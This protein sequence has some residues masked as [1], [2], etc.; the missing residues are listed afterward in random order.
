MAHPMHMSLQT[1][2]FED[3]EQLLA[4]FNER[5]AAT[6]AAN[7]ACTPQFTFPGTEQFIINPATFPTSFRMPSP[8]VSP[9]L[10]SP[11]SSFSVDSSS[12]SGFV[13]MANIVPPRND[14]VFGWNSVSIAQP[15]DESE[16]E[17]H[18]GRNSAEQT[19]QQS[20]RS[21]TTLKRP[22]SPSPTPSL[23]S[24][25]STSPAPMQQSDIPPA[26]TPT[27]KRARA[28]IS[29]K[30]FVPPD[31]SGLSKRE[32]RLVKNR[33]AAFLSRQRKREEFEELEK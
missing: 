1:P 3:N 20:L 24:S 30:D 26:P 10:S 13:S 8:P 29:S 7:P 28:Q 27:P 16:M 32:A 6:W 19:L 33:A 9:S 4:S 2:Y 17:E 23:S 18:L 14:T 25:S 5:Y 31:V 21:R 22:A 15:E 12:T 11:G